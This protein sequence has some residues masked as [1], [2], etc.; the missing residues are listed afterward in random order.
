[1]GFDVDNLEKLLKEDI[2]KFKE[3]FEILKKQ[4]EG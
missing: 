1:M 3:G 4:I 2:E